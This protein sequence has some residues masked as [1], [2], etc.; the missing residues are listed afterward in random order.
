V[1]KL[2]GGE[3]PSLFYRSVTMKKGNDSW[4][5]VVVVCRRRRRRLSGRHR[6]NAVTPRLMLRRRRPTDRG[7]VGAG[8]RP[9]RR[10]DVGLARRGAVSAVFGGATVV[11]LVAGQHLVLDELDDVGE[12]KL[13]PADPAGQGVASHQFRIG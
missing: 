4:H 6:R 10:V 3:H 13:F 5:Q 8:A 11:L 2:A 7:R 9:G 12:G 1:K